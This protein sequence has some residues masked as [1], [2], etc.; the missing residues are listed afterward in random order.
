M[1]DV[2]EFL[3]SHEPFRELDEAALEDLAQRVEV[4][5]FAAGAT[6]L[7]QGGRSQDRIRVVRRG[8]V[9]LVDGDRV[10]DLLGEGEMF[11]HP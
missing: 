4:E 2:A 11:G 1:H 5:F 8:T 10:L 9:E 7:A 6:I 3:S